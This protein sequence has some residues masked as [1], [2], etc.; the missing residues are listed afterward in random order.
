MFGYSRCPRAAET[1]HALDRMAKKSFSLTCSI[2]P[3]HPPFMNVSPYWGMY[4]AKDM[5]LPKNFKHDMTWSLYRERQ[6]R[7]TK[8]QVPENIQAGLSTYYGMIKEVDDQVGRLLGRLEELGLAGNTMVVFTADHGEMMGSHGMGSKM[9]FYEDSVHVPLLIRFPGRIE[10]GILVTEPVS[11]MDLFATTLDYLGSA[12]PQREGYGLL[13]LVEAKGA[14]GPDFRVSEW[15]GEN[16]PNFM[17]RTRDWK[18]IMA[19]NSTSKARDALFN[20][21]EDPYEITN[22][23]GETGDRSK[24]LKQAGEM[25]DRLLE[26]VKRSGSPM[27]AGVRERK[28]I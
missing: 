13:P 5:P 9:V 24:Y 26:W 19:E 2:G 20:M 17:V 12:S 22:L 25:K 11:T 16:V 27:A 15:D 18:L 1:I 28:L 7:T 10:P 23:L 14:S 4:P 8:Y 6:A 21:K 3:P